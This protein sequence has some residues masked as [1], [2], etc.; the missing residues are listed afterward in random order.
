VSCKMLTGCCQKEKAGA[1]WA[2]DLLQ[3]S[4]VRY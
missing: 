3:W 4:L 1:L 2:F